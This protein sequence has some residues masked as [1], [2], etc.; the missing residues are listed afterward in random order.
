MNRRRKII[1]GFVVS[2]FAVLIVLLAIVIIAPKVVDTKTVKA[3]VRS[4]LMKVAGVEIDFEH[5]TL[6]FFPHPHV[7]ID[8][9]T[10]SISSG[11]KGKA[12]SV[13]VQPKILPLFLGKIQLADLRLDSAELNYTL[14]QK[15]ATE[16]TTPQPFSL[17]DL[18]KRIQTVVATLPE[19]KI[20]DLDFRV[21]NSSANLFAGDRKFLELTA[22]NSH[23]AGPPAERKITINCKS[24]LWQRISISGLLNTR[25]FKGSGQI[26]LTQFRP[27][28]LV[29]DLLSDSPVRITDAP[30]K[31][32]IDL[33]TDESGQ[34]EAALKGSSPHLKFHTA[35]DALNI[36]NPLIKAA[37]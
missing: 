28:G 8:Q 26:Q 17:Y 21:N 25:T 13:T 12:V 29:A 1:G 16:K 30:A 6:D 37:I 10:L 15:P 36:E 23:L 20:P 4:E 24:N 34:L 18:G 11:V 7:I 22:V 33:K 3:K 27:Q 9:V 35:K 2:A 5:L 14:P 32:T 31:L 19:F